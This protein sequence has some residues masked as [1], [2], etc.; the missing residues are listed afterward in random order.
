MVKRQH[1]NQDGEFKAASLWSSQLMNQAQT[2][3]P[4]PTP[5]WIQL[6]L[7]TTFAGGHASQSSATSLRLALNQ[8][9][10]IFRFL[11]NIFDPFVTG[12]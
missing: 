7:R 3:F 1:G 2:F 11:P 5:S 8:I 12:V 6:Q 9:Y 4:V 10:T